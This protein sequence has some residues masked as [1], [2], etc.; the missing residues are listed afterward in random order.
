MWSGYGPAQ[1]STEH[2]T[3]PNHAIVCHSTDHNTDQDVG[4]SVVRLTTTVTTEQINKYVDNAFV[5]IADT[6]KVCTRSCHVRWKEPTSST[7]PIGTQTNLQ[8]SCMCHRSTY[9]YA[10]YIYIEVHTYSNSFFSSNN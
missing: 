4:Q 8:S 3:D 2:S 7:V 9:T 1:R 5:F 10:I 6:S